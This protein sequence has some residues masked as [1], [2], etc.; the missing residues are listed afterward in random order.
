MMRASRAWAAT[1]ERHGSLSSDSTCSGR[2]RN[3]DTDRAAPGETSCYLGSRRVGAVRRRATAGKGK[4]GNRSRRRS[5]P[6]GDLPIAGRSAATF[7]PGGGRPTTR[8]VLRR[9][10][11]MKPQTSDG[12]RV[13]EDLRARAGRLV[14]LKQLA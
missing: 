10:W 8:Q 12:R 1:V 3:D 7:G 4:G 9:T 6:S 11:G 13:T 2:V 5:R 14:T